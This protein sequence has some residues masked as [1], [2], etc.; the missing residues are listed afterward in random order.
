MSFTQGVNSA[1]Q[2]SLRRPVGF[3][4]I[5]GILVPWETMEVSNTRY[6]AAGTFRVTLPVSSLPKS[7]PLATLISANTLTVQINAGTPTTLNGISPS[8]LPLLIFGNVDNIALEPSKTLLTISGR[9]YTSFFLDNKLGQLGNSIGAQISSILSFSKSSDIITLIAK[10]RGLTPLVVPTTNPIG[11]YQQQQYNL[12]SNQ[13][14]EWD[15]MAKLAAQEN[16]DL[17]VV[18]KTL[19]FQPTGVF[20]APYN[21][22]LTI[23]FYTTPGGIVSSN[24]I[25]INVQR[26]YKL[27]KNVIVNVQSWNANQKSSYQ[28]TATLSHNGQG[29]GDETPVFYNYRIP[30]LTP[31]QCEQQAKSLLTQ[32][33][34]HEMTLTA[35]LP[36]DELL[37]AQSV[38]QF[39]NTN[40]IF[41]QV[42]FVKNVTR[43]LNQQSYIMSVEATTTPPFSVTL[44][45]TSTPVGD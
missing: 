39:K 12:L 16:Y 31:A 25:D 32:I 42:Y 30:N 14:T 3:L 38:I 26:N 28:S 44:A 19:L 35:R 36:G 17:F 13:I 21:I 27:S 1:P 8:D 45:S 41:D 4:T 10:N 34:G 5:N 22:T 20:I 6:Y 18:G 24:S 23:P 33:S 7:L 43:E 29:T 40:T 2:D 11:I 37:T 9:D 15:L